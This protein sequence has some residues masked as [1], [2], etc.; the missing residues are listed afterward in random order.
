VGLEDERSELL[1][2]LRARRTLPVP[3]E[4]KAIRVVAGASLRDVARVLGTSPASVYR[5][6]EGAS[7]GPLTV[8]YAALLEELQRLGPS[9]EMREPGFPGSEARADENVDEQATRRAG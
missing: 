2:R 5:W 8:A 1:E 7:P 4:R 9:P 6:E 3:S